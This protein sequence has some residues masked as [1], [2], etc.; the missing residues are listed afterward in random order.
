MGKRDMRQRLREVQEERLQ[1]PMWGDRSRGRKDR[2]E[3]Q[4]ATEQG[5]GRAG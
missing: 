4:G 1:K 5:W 2:G 3:R